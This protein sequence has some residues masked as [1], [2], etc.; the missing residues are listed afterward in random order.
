MKPV[1]EAEN[2]LDAN[3]AKGILNQMGIA[4]AIKGEYLQGGIGDIPLAGL[5]TVM[6]EDADELPAREVLQR[7]QDG[8]LTLDAEHIDHTEHSFPEQANYIVPVATGQPFSKAI[9]A[10]LVGAAI[11][12][13]AVHLCYRTPQFSY[14]IDTDGDGVED[15]YL[16]W[17]G[18]Y[19]DREDLDRDQDGRLDGVRQYDRHGILASWQYDDNFDGLFEVSGRT[20]S[21]GNSYF[22]TD[23]N[24][25]GVTD[26]RDHYLYQSIYTMTE[27]YAEDGQQVIKRFIYR[28]KGVSYAELDSDRDGSM[29]TFYLFND[30]DEIEAIFDS[31]AA[32]L[33]EVSVRQSQ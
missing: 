5:V 19:L 9:A 2:A 21:T 26:T 20:R 24:G 6:V 4:A 17:Q 33:K 31:R 1:Y 8:E 3:L 22:D 12:G 7:W 18:N 10:F 27:F 13:T 29:D 23:R 15:T 16:H 14:G 30:I 25:D 11:A 28:D 32:L